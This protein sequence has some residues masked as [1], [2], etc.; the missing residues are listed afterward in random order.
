ME[1][2]NQGVCKIKVRFCSIASG[3]KGNCYY[4]ETKSSKI[5]IDIGIS[6][7]ELKARLSLIGVDIN[8]INAALVSH[9]HGDHTRSVGSFSRSLDK[10]VYVNYPT[11]KAVPE[12]MRFKNVHEFDSAEPFMISDLLI[13]PFSVSHDA[14]DP[15]GFTISV[16]GKKIGIATDLGVATNLVKTNLSD[17]DILIIESN[18]DHDLL[19]NGPYPWH[20][21]QRIRSRHGHLSNDD[22]I[23]LINEVVC[24]NT[25]HVFLAHLSE[26]N[27]DEAKAYQNVMNNYKNGTER[28]IEFIVTNQYR[29]A[30]IVT[31]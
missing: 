27:N 15:V 20:L 5:L 30:A 25:T 13:T 3:S 23:E 10:S 22:A 26:T 12:T 4:L 18:H 6:L 16:E 14:A 1:Q 28:P 9:E 19:I 8:D 11:L 21:K 2:S 29:P 7:K 31:A 24:D 17:C